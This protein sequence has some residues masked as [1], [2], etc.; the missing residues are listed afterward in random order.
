MMPA[1]LPCTAGPFTQQASVKEG[2]PEKSKT[3]PS[4]CPA[5]GDAATSAPEASALN[6]NAPFTT[7]ETHSA[8]SL[9]KPAS[10][11]FLPWPEESAAVKPLVSS[12]FHQATRPVFVSGAGSALI[13]RIAGGALVVDPHGL[14]STT[15]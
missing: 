12:N 2:L 14:L 10:W 4:D 6:C 11:A 8:G 5:A 3:P 13:A 15:V 7:P 1:P 9:L